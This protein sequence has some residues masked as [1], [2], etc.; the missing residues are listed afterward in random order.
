MLPSPSSFPV[1]LWIA[2]TRKAENYLLEAKEVTED[3]EDIALRHWLPLYLEQ[4]RYE[5]VMNGKKWRSGKCRH[6]LEY[7]SCLG[8]LEEV[9]K[10][11]PIY[12][13]ALSRF[14]ENPEFLES[15]SYLLRVGVY[16]KARETAENYCS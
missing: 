1:G 6:P 11:G 4:E 2:P 10:T 13:E 5:D 16:R 12:E 8:N 9:E 15:Y 14:E 7:R 3:L